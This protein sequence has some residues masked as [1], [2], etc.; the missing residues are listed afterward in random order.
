M[1][2]TAP[3]ISGELWINTDPLTPQHLHG[4]V[5]VLVFWSSGCEASLLRLRQVQSLVTSA[6][7]DADSVLA[8]AVHTPRMTCDDDV[9]RLQH[10][11][12]RHRLTI[13]IVH[14]PRYLTW[15]RYEP[16]GWP[17][18]AIIDRR[19]RIT[20]IAAGCRDVEVI[21]QALED[22]R[23][24]SGGRRREDHDPLPLP[25]P[26]QRPGDNS[27]RHRS[28]RWL[29][30]PEGLAAITA[31]TAST[32]LAVA[33]TGHDRILIGR[34][35]PG[36]HT[37]LVDTAITGFDQPTAVVFIDSGTLAVVERGA[38]TVSVVDVA[39]GEKSVIA[40]RLARPVGLTVDIDGSVIITD[41]GADMLYRATAN[42]DRSGH[43]I[44]P[45][46]GSG[47]TGVESGAAHKAELAQPVAVTRTG[48][49]LV[50]ADAASSNLRL[51]IDRGDVVNIT[52]SDLFDWGLIDGPAH[53][54][55][56]QRPSGLAA[57][58]DGSVVVVDS[59]NDR[60]RRLHRRRVETLGLS[61]L[62]APTAVA[63]LG[64]GRVV[65]A[66]T[67]N[68]R[69]VVVDPARQDAWPM[70]IDGVDSARSI[71]ARARDGDGDRNQDQVWSGR[72][73]SAT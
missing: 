35:D 16:P 4:R 42:R 41:A 52:D 57:L 67:H 62:N 32:R 44:L 59:G 9:E 34:T 2:P 45:I 7:D 66:D 23:N 21:E 56:L 55:R 73:A 60:L 36:I 38:D 49:G 50:F 22:A 10:V 51:L 72:A 47:R 64:D 63:A 3:P 8:V 27:S 65:V 26:D 5:V 18:T 33:D 40:D 71:A 30:Y 53:R 25:R 68:H 69:L 46:A 13:P 54:A 61:G 15:T 12:R 28:P 11:I 48:A 20:G 43:L 24:R 58:G 14:D 70:T 29:N 39:T 1:A 31:G 37:H 6:G 17:S 19:G